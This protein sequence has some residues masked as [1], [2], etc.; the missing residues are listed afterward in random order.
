M[1]DE[2]QAASYSPDM[3]I[4][5]LAEWLGDP[6]VAADFPQVR[7]RFR[8][9]RHA[10]PIGLDNLPDEEWIKHF[11][12]FAPLPDNLRQPLALRYHGHQ[13]RVY[14]PEIG[15]GR[16]FLFAQMR[17]AEG[18]L[19][20]LGT[21]GSGPTPWS[22]FG[23]GRLTLKGAVREILAT[24]M[25]EALG[26]YTSKTFSVIE[27]GEE[28]QRNDE[29]SPTRSAVLTRLSHG[30]IRIGTFQRLLALEQRDHME[31][32]VDYCLTQFPGPLPPGD[33]PGR[34]EPAVRL[35]HLVVERLADLAAS[36][37]VAGFV[38]GVLNT[39][40][41][42]ITGESFDYGP[43]RFLP[44][45]DPE[46]TAAYFDHQGLYAFGRQ[47]E[48][49][50]W[51]CGQF[52]IALRLL[53]DAPPLIAAMERF[54]P[55]YME[56]VGQRWCWRLGVASRGTEADA[57]LVAAC[58]AHLRDSGMA[59]DAF[60]FRHRGGR[61]TDGAL[62]EALK[63]YESVASSHPY[64]SGDGPQGMLIEEV[65]AVWAAIDR[66]DDWSPLHEKIAA[67][68]VMGAAHGSPPPPAG[69]AGTIGV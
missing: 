61:A 50:H 36:W 45:W 33:A 19:L 21:K 35:M 56:A 6:V 51:N 66:D 46:F 37:M 23:D 7:L 62:A 49:L 47:P 44:R 57:A 25:L 16:G 59:P 10:A 18:R 41:M 30:H 5:Q 53:A 39:D 4:M 31:E 29:P 27:T 32:L 15:D 55:L 13:F 48:A 60:F 20:D 2:P 43:W 64:W 54:G 28:L 3:P 42:N 67:L 1:R 68:R 17:D 58:E 8:N 26:V 38:H 12:R 24:E 63:G 34:E 65:E 14:N 40:N 22:R 9:D 52:A 11:G 69:H